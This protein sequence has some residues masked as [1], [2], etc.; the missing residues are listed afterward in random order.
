VA[1][2]DDLTLVYLD[3]ETTGLSPE[4]GDRVCEIALLKASGGRTLDAFDTLLNP[5]HPISP[6]ASA[7]NGI[8]DEMV[9]N[10]PLF[11]N[12]VSRVLDF[13][14]DPE[15]VLVAHNAPFD[16]KFL[17][18]E[19]KRLSIPLPG[20]PV[21]DTL[22]LARRCY[23]FPSN[24]L[25]RI[26]LSLGIPIGVRHRAMPDVLTTKEVLEVFLI[27]FRAHSL[28]SLE[29][30]LEIQAGGTYAPPSFPIPPDLEEALQHGKKV[31][32]RYLSADGVQTS[33]WIEP[34]QIEAR[35]DMLYVVAYCHLRQAERSFRLDR[36]LEIRPE[37]ED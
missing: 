31:F 23:H 5:E 18:S 13:F 14:Y 35:M 20:L 1:R 16:L 15:S 10:Q 4:Y 11:L 6:G 27:D 25:P 34:L 32:I 28:D 8:T 24:S 9:R 17:E 19:L 33:R 2:I 21:L 36:I 22:R 12:V 26:A 29:A 30:L 3:V 37:G 7:V